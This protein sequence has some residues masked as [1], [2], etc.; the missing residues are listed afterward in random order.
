MHSQNPS[1]ITIFSPSSTYHFNTVNLRVK[2]VAPC[3]PP[4]TSAQ[5]RLQV[6][7][8]GQ[9]LH[10]PIHLIS[11]HPVHFYLRLVRCVTWCV[12]FLGGRRSSRLP[13]PS[14]S[15]SQR[16]VMESISCKG[17]LASSCSVLC[18]LNDRCSVLP[19]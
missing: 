7:A 10:S 12:F 6:G 2:M 18:S 11:V 13:K 1:P 14:S 15:S 16:K 4:P 8:R 19:D 3:P 5:F 17:V 9:P